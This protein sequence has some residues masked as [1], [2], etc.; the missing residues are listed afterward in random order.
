[1]SMH[2]DRRGVR[3]GEAASD[4]K[5]ARWFPAR[6]AAWVF[7]LGRRR[8]GGSDRSVRHDPID[9]HRNIHAHIESYAMLKI[10]R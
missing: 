4:L 8:P 5:E 6:I 2:N 10:N 1:M 7:R 3:D 9:E